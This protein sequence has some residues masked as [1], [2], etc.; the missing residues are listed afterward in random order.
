MQPALW[1]G[2]SDNEGGRLSHSAPN[3]L[4][5]SD[6]HLGEGIRPGALGAEER[7]SDEALVAFLDHYASR[8]RGDRPW[9]LVI[10]GDMV[11]FVAVCIM[12][13]Q[14]DA[15][16]GLHE[17]DHLYGLG[18][19]AQPAAHKLRRVM[20]HH[21]AVF[22]ALAR[23]VGAGHELAV[24]TGNHDAA[25]HWPAVQ[26]ELR[27]GI[28]Q[29]LGEEC[30]ASAW[31][32]AAAIRF[33]PWFLFEDGVAW[34]EHGHQYDPYC[35]FDDV[36]EPATDERD[37]D[38]NVG[39]AILHYVGN[40]MADDVSHYWGR[41]FFGFLK[42][43]WVLG[44]KRGLDVLAGYRDMIWRL[45]GHWRGR[46]AELV[47]A[48]RT[49]SRARLA[50]IAR[51]VRLPE[52]VLVKL[53]RLR[54]RPIAIDLGRTLHALMLDRL[55]LLLAGPLLLIA[56]LIA[57]P[58]SWL[59]GALVGVLGVLLLWVRVAAGAREPV[60]P[61]PALRRTSRKIRELAR[62]PIVVFGHTH[63]ALVDR[64]R[65]GWMFNSGTW[66]PHKG[67]L[68]FTH[69]RIERTE[70]GV[71]AMLCQWREGRS[72]GL[73][74]GPAVPIEVLLSRRSATSSTAPAAPRPRVW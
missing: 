16:V 38:P 68:A 52:E 72:R 40:H 6:L 50:R 17:D 8:R 7:R 45:V 12:P 1:I 41:G 44:G 57:V 54:I 39:S 10:N 69:V 13:D 62:V 5:I 36:L 32:L 73:G 27:A 11:D 26:E 24:V 21:D 37:L 67:L 56:P 66:M 65:D 47:A 34:I 61:R 51:K 49:R 14:S 64:T 70:R 53:Q 29:R 31:D 71:K 46:H 18:M 74:A 23:F 59:P 19:R 35:S 30:G 4:V 42:V 63:Q 15:V 48:R 60:D 3:L 28:A 55:L 2:H 58:W 9:R 33:H 43:P 25:F 20:D 22:R